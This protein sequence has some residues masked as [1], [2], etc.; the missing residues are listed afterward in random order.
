M[1]F[2]QGNLNE[3]DFDQISEIENGIKEES[4]HP[5]IEEY[6]LHLSKTAESQG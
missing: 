6:I 4:Y 2:H 1:N 5:R 3:N